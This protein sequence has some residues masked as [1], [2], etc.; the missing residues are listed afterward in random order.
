MLKVQGIEA[1][2]VSEQQPAIIK[3]WVLMGLFILDFIP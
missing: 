2:A 1:V 3:K